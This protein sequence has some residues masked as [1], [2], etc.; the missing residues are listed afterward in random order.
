MM[1]YK[2][3]VEKWADEF[4]EKGTVLVI[5]PPEIAEWVEKKLISRDLWYDTKPE[6]MH[7]RF[8]KSDTRPY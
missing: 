8:I 6:G 5:G 2:K 1:D 3:L 4:E 7:V